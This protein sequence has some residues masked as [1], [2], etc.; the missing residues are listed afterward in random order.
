MK[1]TLIL[2]LIT[3]CSCTK[4]WVC[5]IKTQSDYNYSTYY[6]DF[7]G[8]SEEKEQYEQESTATYPDGQGGT[9][10]TVTNCVPD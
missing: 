6:V 10:S 2:S 9:V 3:L 8:T 1:K 4:D 7:R 5:E